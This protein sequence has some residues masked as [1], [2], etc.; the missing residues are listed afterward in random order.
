MTKSVTCFKCDESNLRWK[1]DGDEWIIVSKD[2]YKHRCNPCNVYEKQEREAPQRRI[3]TRRR[4]IGVRLTNR[5]LEDG[6]LDYL[7]K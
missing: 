7:W 4:L 1:K 3:E 5:E 2:G 6:S